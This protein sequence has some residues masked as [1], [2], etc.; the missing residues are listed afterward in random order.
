[1]LLCPCLFAVEVHLYDAPLCNAAVHVGSV[2][3]FGSSN[4][5]S[6]VGHLVER[7]QAH[8][9][10]NS[11]IIVTLKRPYYA[12]LVLLFPLVC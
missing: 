4:D 3:G 2:Q 6:A 10:E 7:L 8:S 5:S 1:M 11:L 12:F 9:L